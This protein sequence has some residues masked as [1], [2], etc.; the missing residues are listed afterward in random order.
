L[1]RKAKLD[2][3]M[4]EE[5]RAHVEMRTQANIAAG[6]SP[7]EA[8]SAATRSFGGMEQ[9]KEVCRDL[10]GVGWIEALGQDV[11]FGLRLLRRNPAFTGIAVL[12]LGLGLT[13]S[14][15][16]F[17]FVDGIWLR[18]M[19]FAD[20]TQLVRIF[21]G[22]SAAPRG[23]LCFPDYQDLVAQMG[24]V[25]GLAFNNLRDAALTGPRATGPEGREELRADLVSRNFFSVLGI[26]PFLGRFFSEADAADLRN[27]RGVVLSYRLWQRRFGGDTNV[28]GQAIE[29]TGGEWASPV[30]LGIAPPGF[31]GLERL[32]PAEVWY[33]PESWGGDRLM[34]SH[35]GPPLTLI[36]RL[37]LGYTARQAQAEAQAVMRRLDLRDVESGASLHAAVVTEAHLQFERTGSLSLLL[38]G[39]VGTVLLLACANVSS[40]LLARA[41]VRPQEMGV[42]VALG[43]SRWRLIRQLL[44]ESLVLAFMA[45]AV[46]LVLAKWIIAAAPALCPAEFADA[47]VRFDGRV[48]AFGLAL[49]GLTVFVFGLAP[50][51]R[52]TR[53]AVGP[54]LKGEP[55]LGFTGRHRTALSGLVVGQTCAAL[56]L[57]SLAALLARSL[58]ACSAGLGF[59]RKPILL[60]VVDLWGKARHKEEAGRLICRDIKERLLALP[61]VKRVSVAGVP[62]LWDRALGSVKV[63]SPDGGTSAAQGGGAVQFNI[64]D[65]DYFA[66]LGVPVLRGRG[67]TD[68][69]DLASPR[70]MVINET[71]AKRFWPGA[72]SIGQSLCL[73]SMTNQPVRIVGVVRNSK[74]TK[75]EEEP[76]ACLYLPFGQRYHRWVFFLIESAKGV[77]ALVDPVRSELRAAG[78]RPSLLVSMKAL[79][80]GTLSTKRF[81]ARVSVALGLVSLALAS[82]GLY[83]VLSYTVN[84]RTREIGVRMALGAQRHDVLLMILRQ[85]L[86]LAVLGLVLA[87]PVLLAL[88]HVVR[89]FLYGVSP[90][91]PLSL[92]A[93]ALVLLVVAVLAAYLPARRAMSTDPMA[94][95]R[96]E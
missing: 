26:R 57:V 67:L 77:A 12:S 62:P 1:F 14:C 84:R 21:A 41:E 4:D 82:V 45:G 10:R 71:M 36:A 53:Q 56:V 13:L 23:G 22:S 55:S 81:L 31:R 47:T 50:A 63:Y 25:S 90:L 79:I 24:S 59:E 17:S 35:K 68:R 48:V 51:L 32:N 96:Y 34:W 11:R 7:D 3:E 9:I 28:V 76:E 78:M 91:D 93:A 38:L 15:A 37:K 30:V 54:A 58:M 72:D 75:I 44:T 46:S 69:D 8:R 86:S 61:G 33:P 16:V 80:D 49:S 42:R 64:A 87:A 94:A 85:G 65:G 43:A 2:Q 89:A 18:L 70:V 73:E 19:P 66:L 88:S 83:G 29:L 5:M 92:G 74:L 52:L 95:L 40:L 39:M 27:V 20:P 6:M 60:A